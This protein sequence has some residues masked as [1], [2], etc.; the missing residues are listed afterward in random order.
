VIKVGLTRRFVVMF[1]TPATNWS[2]S[3]LQF[4]ELGYLLDD[5]AGV[6]EG[7]KA[8]ACH[9]RPDDVVVMEAHL[10]AGT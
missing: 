10:A 3:I 6:D 8:F 9:L 5:L 2:A 7:F 4:D 1:E